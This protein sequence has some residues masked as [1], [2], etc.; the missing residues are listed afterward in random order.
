ML[1]VWKDR[2]KEQRGVHAETLVT[3]ALVLSWESSKCGTG[4]P[5]P[6][7]CCCCCLVSAAGA[8]APTTAHCA[9]GACAARLSLASTAAAASD[10][11]GRADDSG[12][13]TVGGCTALG[14]RR[15][16]WWLGAAVTGRGLLLRWG[17]AH[18]RV[19]EG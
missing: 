11:S 14:T 17:L 1:P 18:G 16:G 15:G 10:E 19:S 12:G 2:Q 8:T 3:Q 13:G 7:R 4:D 5:R 6:L 9:V